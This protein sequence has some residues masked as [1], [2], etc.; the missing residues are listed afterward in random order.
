[1]SAPPLCEPVSASA[2]RRWS[3][4]DG[5]WTRRAG[6]SDGPVLAGHEGV[7]VS[8]HA[9]ADDGVPVSGHADVDDLAVS[10]HAEEADGVPGSVHSAGDGEA[11][12]SGHAEADGL[13]RAE[14]V[15]GGV[16]HGEAPGSDSGHAAGNGSVAGRAAAVSSRAGRTGGRLADGSAGAAGDVGDAGWRTG[17]IGLD[18][19]PND[20]RLGPPGVESGVEGSAGA[21]GSETASGSAAANQAGSAASGRAGGRR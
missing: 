8:G 15:L 4:V 7:A 13:G 10:G 6:T 14:D 1:M 11:A 21:D 16:V 2:R 3:P 5:S 9:E 20:A 12:R 18:V 19:K 17:E